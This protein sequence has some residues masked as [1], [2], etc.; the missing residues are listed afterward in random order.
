MALNFFSA[1]FSSCPFFF[2]FLPIFASDCF[3]AI[4]WSCLR[5]TSCD[6]KKLTHTHTHTHTHTRNTTSSRQQRLHMTDTTTKKNWN[7]PE[8]M[9][10]KKKQKPT[11]RSAFERLSHAS[12]NLGSNP[13]LS[14][15][16]RARTCVPLAPVDEA[17]STCVYI[18]THTH[19]HAL[20]PFLCV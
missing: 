1:R 11:F 5:K 17:F 2:S 9:I 14:G 7:S 20:F 13:G 6:L 16:I 3:V 18:F 4:C 8:S 15:F 19:A 12:L 10:D